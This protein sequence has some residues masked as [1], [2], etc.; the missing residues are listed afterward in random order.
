MIINT[1]QITLT[2]E[3]LTKV[4]KE[5]KDL[6]SNPYIILFDLTKTNRPVIINSGSSTPSQNT[7]QF[8]EF[9]KEALKREKSYLARVI[10]SPLAQAEL[11]RW[12]KNL[13]ILKKGEFKSIIATI[14]ITNRCITER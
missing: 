13:R 14:S 10:I 8:Q 9:Q 6:L 7:I 3:K 2:E 1:L 11:M 12:R 5:C 4:A